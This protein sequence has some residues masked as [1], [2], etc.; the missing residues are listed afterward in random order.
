MAEVAENDPYLQRLE[1][2]TVSLQKCQQ[3]RGLSSCTPC[4][5]Q[6]G[7]ERRNTYVTAVYQSMN[8][9]QGGGFDFQ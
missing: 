9:G 8:K 7:C 3:E 6:M 1:E 5:H 4:E 2:E